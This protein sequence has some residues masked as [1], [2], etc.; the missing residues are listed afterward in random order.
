MIALMC[1]LYCSQSAHAHVKWFAGYDWS[2]PPRAFVEVLTP[3]TWLMLC[4]SLVTL[5]VSVI[6]DNRLGQIKAL[7][8]LENRL[9]RRRTSSLMM[10]RI[11]AFAT[12]LVAWQQGNLFAPELTNPSIWVERLQF[13]IILFLF[14]VQTTVAA[15]IGM[16]ALW[17][18]GASTFGIFHM[19][20][21]VNVIGFSWFLIVRPLSNRL[22]QATAL[23]VLYT[24]TGLSLMWLGCEKLVFPDWA[25][26]LLEQN[27]MLTLGLPDE[28]FLTGAA[29][30][31]LGLGFM[32]IICLFS[33]SLSLAITLVFFMTTCVFGKVEVIGHTLIHASLIVFLFEG[34]GHTFTPPAMFHERMPM[35][36]AFATVNFV[37]VVVAMIN[38][39]SATAVSVV[40]DHQ[41]VHV[42]APFD[43]TDS[44]MRP[45][46]QLTVEPDKH[47][48]WNIQV[49]TTNFRFTP[50]RTGTEP[51]AGE[52]HAHL[53]LDGNKV[54][55]M[56][57]PWY[58]IPDP[59]IGPH[60]LRVALNANDHSEFAFDGTPVQAV[61]NFEVP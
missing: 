29:F 41:P 33:R 56:Y 1:W 49:T 45:D 18:I 22:L 36:I 21:Y 3:T 8:D 4:I 23:P 48:G 12:L 19:L 59:G 54:A 20:D 51:V 44:P 34:P 40:R 15:G 42:H 61:V 38:I 50:D 5:T 24:T 11:A 26:R 10:M 35:R 30:V 55:R 28:Y 46:V 52:G 47:A 60:E 31:E 53:Y 39:Y 9:E 43:V 25:L 13:V 7:Q 32:L 17:I 6:G 27:P 58:H 2:T 57:G 16:L 37:I 14:S